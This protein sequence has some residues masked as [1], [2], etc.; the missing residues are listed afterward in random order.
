MAKHANVNKIQQQDVDPTT[1]NATKDK[2]PL[3][4]KEVD[5][6]DAAGAGK[7]GWKEK[8]LHI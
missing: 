8:F 6:K 1:P 2:S 3:K 5:K 4:G 7:S